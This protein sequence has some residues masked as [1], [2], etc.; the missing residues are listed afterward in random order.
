MKMNPV[1]T[2][3]MKKKKKP[4][5]K[6]F[7]GVPTPF[8]LTTNMTKEESFESKSSLKVPEKDPVF[9]SADSTEQPSETTKTNLK[10]DDLFEPEKTEPKKIEKKLVSEDPFDDDIFDKK[11]TEKVEPK[12]MAK[13][14]TTDPFNEI[15]EMIEKKYK[16]NRI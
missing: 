5:K 4:V 3:V 1:G 13:S 15:D 7:M 9:E 11:T 14:V 2:T 12:K 16:E 6:T 8:A 10:D